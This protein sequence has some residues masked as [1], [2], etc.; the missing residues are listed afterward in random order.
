M[1]KIFGRNINMIKLKQILNESPHRVFLSNYILDC[2]DSDT[3]TFGYSEINKKFNIIKTLDSCHLDLN[4]KF[5]KYQGRYWINKKI[6]SFW[7]Y[8]K[9]KKILLD[10]LQKIDNKLNDIKIEIIFD[11]NN[12]I[13]FDRYSVS[14][15]AQQLEDLYNGYIDNDEI[16][17]Y[18]DIIPI[19][20]Y[21]KKYCQ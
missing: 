5:N 3:I 11:N 13:K 12:I 1:Q 14:N 10:L 19:I 20:D 9:D 6:L 2:G 18:N 7:E 15:A 16:Q 21:I 4:S 17:Y 8:P